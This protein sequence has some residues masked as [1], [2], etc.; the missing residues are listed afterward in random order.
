MASLCRALQQTINDLEHTCPACGR[1]DFKTPKGILSHMSQ[2][3]GCQWY[4]KGKLQDLRIHEDANEDMELEPFVGEEQNADEENGGD[5]WDPQ[6]FMEGFSR[7]RRRG[8]RQAG[9]C[10]D[11]GS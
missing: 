11:A 5:Q 3:K 9:R 4:H 8:I 10:C 2:A 6:E 1:S 7:R